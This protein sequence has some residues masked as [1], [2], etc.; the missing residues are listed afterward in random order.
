M[1]LLVTI[2]SR[3]PSSVNRISLKFFDSK[4][5]QDECRYCRKHLELTIFWNMVTT[6]SLGTCFLSCRVVVSSV[7]EKSMIFSPG[8]ADWIPEVSVI[9]GISA[10]SGL[11]WFIEGDCSVEESVFISKSGCGSKDRWENEQILSDGDGERGRASELLISHE[12]CLKW[13]A[14]EEKPSIFHSKRIQLDLALSLQESQSMYNGWGDD[15]ETVKLYDSSSIIADIPSS[16]T[17]KTPS[18]ILIKLSALF[19]MLSPVS[20]RKSLKST[21]GSQG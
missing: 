6:S 21:G 9:V 11:T 14:Y 13:F 5:L 19:M 12:V 18:S 20:F 7:D 15:L 1:S 17:V 8:I 4:I 16:L 10:A 2:P 3:W